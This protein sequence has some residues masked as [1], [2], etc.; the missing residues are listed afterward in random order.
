M[1][2]IS[3]SRITAEGVSFEWTKI[4]FWPLSVSVTAPPPTTSAAEKVLGMVITGSGSTV[5]SAAW[6]VAGGSNRLTKSTMLRP[7]GRLTASALAM[8]CAAPPPIDTIASKFWGL[9]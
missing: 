8:S 6:K 5:T 7:L 2:A 1:A 3:A 4:S 9:R